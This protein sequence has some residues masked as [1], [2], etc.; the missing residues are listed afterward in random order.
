MLEKV[1]AKAR[2][3]LRHRPHRNN[4]LLALQGVKMS[5]SQK[6]RSNKNS[7]TLIYETD[8]INHDTDDKNFKLNLHFR[9]GDLTLEE[10]TFSLFS[11]LAPISD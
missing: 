3:H 4:K 6:Q 1:K 8:Y 7:M 2:S 11:P 5:R 9:Q 10:N